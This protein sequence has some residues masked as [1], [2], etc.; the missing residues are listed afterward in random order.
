MKK[1]KISNSQEDNQWKQGTKEYIQTTQKIYRENELQNSSYGKSWKTAL[2]ENLRMDEELIRNSD[3]NAQ[4]HAPSSAKTLAFSGGD[5]D[6]NQ[7]AQG[8]DEQSTRL[9]RPMPG[10]QRCSTTIR[11]VLQ[12]KDSVMPLQ[13]EKCSVCGDTAKGNFF[14]ALVCLPCKVKLTPHPFR[15]LTR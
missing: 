12:M 15:P 14:G 10:S 2:Q 7:R 4:Y 5:K 9:D 13:D 3:Y 11:S 6:E 8:I 1:L